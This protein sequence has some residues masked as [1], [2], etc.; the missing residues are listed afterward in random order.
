MDA[1]V[2]SEITRKRKKHISVR[3]SLPLITETPK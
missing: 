1:E 3:D 2:S